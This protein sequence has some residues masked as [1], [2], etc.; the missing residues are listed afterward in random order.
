MKKFP[1][2]NFK[3]W[4]DGLNHLK[5]ISSNLGPAKESHSRNN[6]QWSCWG[7]KSGY[8]LEEVEEL[9]N[10]VRD[11]YVDQ[12]GQDEYIML[13]NH[14][15]DWIGSKGVNDRYILGEPRVRGNRSLKTVKLFETM[16]GILEHQKARYPAK[17]DKKVSQSNLPL[18]MTNMEFVPLCQYEN[19]KREFRSLGQ[20]FVAYKSKVDAR[21][22]RLEGREFD[23]AQFK[24]KRPR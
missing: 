15:E 7:A 10:R 22:E 9:L 8:S 16:Y 23:M 2:I 24:I 19:L 13:H 17:V 4:T 11:A 12:M 1:K 18:Q 20:E 5:A 21:L 6:A 14:F 3:S